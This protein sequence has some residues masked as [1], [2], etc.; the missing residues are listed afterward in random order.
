MQRV[1]E[2]GAL[3]AFFIGASIFV[4]SIFIGGPLL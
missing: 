2:Y 3:V 1:G 4:Y